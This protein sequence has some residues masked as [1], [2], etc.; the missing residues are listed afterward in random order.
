VHWRRTTT[1]WIVVVVVVVVAGQRLQLL[2]EAGSSGVVRV[3]EIEVGKE[4]L[5]T[6]GQTVLEKGGGEGATRALP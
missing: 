3:R 4:L 6:I 5:Q 1:R 2:A